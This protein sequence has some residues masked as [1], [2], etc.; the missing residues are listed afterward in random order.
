MNEGELKILV[1][2]D[3][4]SNLRFLA[5]LLTENG[6]KVQKA[7]S[8]E[9]ALNAAL[10]SPPD[11]ILL[12]IL[13][14]QMNGYEVCQKLKAA[15][16]TKE[17]PIIFLSALH[18][19]EEQVK[20]F[21]LGGV[22]YI[23]KPFQPEE[24]L[25]RVKNQLTISRLQRQLVAQ[26]HQL[27]E[28]QSLLASVLNSSL[29]GVAA[30]AAIRNREGKISDF[31]WLLLNPTAEKIIGQQKEQLVG[32]TLLESLPGH[33]QTGLLDLYIS[34]VETGK[35]Q[36][37][38]IYYSGD[39][40]E[41][42]FHVSAVKLSDGLAVTFRDISIRKQA[43]KRLKLLERAIAAS[44]NGAIVTD[45]QAPGNPIVYVNSGFERL[46]GYS[47]A[48]VLGKNFHFLEPEDA[49]PR[50]IAKLRQCFAQ[51]SECQVLLR[52]LR[53]DGTFFWH[54]LTISPVRSDEGDLTHYIGIQ[55]DVSDRK[56]YEIELANAKTALEKQIH[57][58]LLLEKITQ[59]IRSSL[60]PKQIF[61]TA[62]DRIGAAFG[63]SRCLIHT[64]IESAIP[65]IP[66]VAE[67]I[68]I[69][70]IASVR[71]L[72]PNF[73]VPIFGNAHI[74]QIL[75]Q[76]QAIASDNIDTEPFLVEVTSLCRQLGIKSML[77]VRTSYQGRPNGVVCLHQCDRYRHWNNDEIALLE[78]VA[79]QIGIAIA[80]ADLLEQE[81]QRRVFL[82]W[83]NQ[84]LQ[85]EIQTRQ[86]TEAALRISEQRWELALRGTGDGIFDWNIQ[87]DEVFFSTRLKEMLGYSEIDN[88]NS[89]EEW[90]DRIHPD[91][92]EQVLAAVQAH[93]QGKT[94]Q[95]LAE[96][97]LRCQ[98]GSYK[99]ILS[100]G[101][102]EWDEAGNPLRMV[103]SN[104]DISDRKQ[105]EVVLQ[106][107][108]EAAEAANHAK[109]NFLASMSHELRTPLNAI[110]GFSQMLAHD[111]SLNRQQQEYINIINRSGEHLLTLINDILSM[112]KIEAGRIVLK[113]NPLNLYHLLNT[114]TE[115]LQ[116]KA[117]GKN[118][119]LIL[120][121]APD[122]PRY[123]KA[124]E[125]KL[126][127]VLINLLGN[128]IKFTH[129]GS[130]C[131]RVKAGIT[132]QA[133]ELNFNQPPTTQIIFEVEDTG[134]GI[135]PEEI[136][137]LFNP[138]V[139][140]T[141]VS[142]STEGTGLGL[143]ISKEFVALMK[144]EIVVRSIVGQGSTFT[145]DIKVSLAQAAEIPQQ[146]IAK[147]VI[148]LEPN[149]PRYRILVV[150]DVLENR[151]L[152]VKLLVELGLEIQEASNGQEAVE[153][154]SRWR[155][156]LIL[157]DIRMPVMDGLEA[158]KIIKQNH[159][160]HPTVIIAL[161]ASA[162]EE[163][164]A[165]VLAAGCDDFISKPLSKEVLWEKLEERLGLRFLF[166]EELPTLSTPQPKF[167]LTKESLCV[168]PLEWREK[169]YH[170]SY[171]L[172]EEKIN[173]LVRKIPS[174]EKSLAEAIASLIDNFRLDLLIEISQQAVEETVETK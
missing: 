153:I 1:V 141:T 169:L 88:W 145:F 149:Q 146:V 124:D 59:E 46:T 24:V 113:E 61:P 107:A 100:R 136:E 32:Q 118:L 45:A 158:T 72:I 132:C 56:Q 85:Q 166:A 133:N 84:Q 35:S 11:L 126:R 83:Q 62:A 122:V 19:V 13:M 67:Y 25:V 39:G 135:A 161:T 117:H 51:G 53:K 94:E 44:F 164:R 69:G 43:Q 120:D 76:D 18:E 155:P 26:N 82:A 89:L 172:D 114:L 37:R 9:L 142:K 54:E 116:L 103:G 144:G 154:F 63:A 57:K 70:S 65:E 93:F 168:M 108:K 110:L 41:A 104:Q 157:M 151:Q 109:S 10:D 127:Q 81:T 163:N 58:V 156:D 138:F 123:I 119:E 78:A 50:E 140:T 148:G 128:A 68:Q 111:A 125:S 91:D 74:Q 55:V 86:Q 131:L 152:I 79:A 42:W 97:R 30:F 129:R 7:I 66:L 28:S 12:D 80:Q 5:K 143:A 96:Y 170:A 106:Q 15:P 147:R 174:S 102:T 47:A 137:T 27:Q 167:S 134:I 48:E 150:E 139:Q 112:S 29:D 36:E 171:T 4:P 34:V 71:E 121:I 160:S 52:N 159:Q 21:N 64:Y 162:F 87:T 49:D 165:T 99:W 14:P 92:V 77:A 33:Q 22:D 115:M 75:A 130:V 3:K 90:R 20:A 98:D 31:R 40:I 105:T 95:Y 23:T 173:E 73:Q 17:I 60:D 6:Y 8:G 2:D 16:P 38:E 101:Q